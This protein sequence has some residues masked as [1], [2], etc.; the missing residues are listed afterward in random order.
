MADKTSIAEQV[1]QIRGGGIEDHFWKKARRW[2]PDGSV[3]WWSVQ[4]VFPPDILTS[5]QRDAFHK[6]WGVGIA[7]SGGRPL[8]EQLVLS[9]SLDKAEYTG[10]AIWGPNSEAFV[11]GALLGKQFIEPG[12]EHAG[13]W[14]NY[15]SEEHPEPNFSE[16]TEWDQ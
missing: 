12:P 14:L 16:P 10:V 15:Q 13:A 9:Y 1:A 11:R 4:V 7:G 8:D 6:G 2:L 3:F 5:G